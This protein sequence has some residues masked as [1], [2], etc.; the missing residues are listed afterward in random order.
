[1][2]RSAVEPARELVWAARDHPRYRWG[3]VLVGLGLG[4][5]VA[6]WHWIGFVLVGLGVAVAAPT[7]RWAL[8]TAVGLGVLATVSFLGWLWWLGL[9]DAAI[10]TGVLL[11]VAV[12]IPLALV[13]LGSAAR[14]VG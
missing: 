9:L 3:I 11:G 4:A 8:V 2:N 14:L 13:L 10:E 1:M 5:A 6:L 7:R 12:A